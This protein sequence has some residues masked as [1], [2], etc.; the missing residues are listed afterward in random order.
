MK[1]YVTLIDGNGEKYEVLSEFGNITTVRLE[2]GR[3]FNIPK[4]YLTEY[5]PSKKKSK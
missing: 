5:S 1:K 4:N 2:N 3:V